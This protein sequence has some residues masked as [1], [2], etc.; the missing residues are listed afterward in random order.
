MKQP[1]TW[2]GGKQR[3]SKHIISLIPEHQIYTESFFGGGSIFFN[4]EPAKCEIINDLN[5]NLINFYQVLKTDFDELKKEVDKTLYSRDEFDYARFIYHYPNFFDNIKRAWALW[6][7]TYTTYCSKMDDTFITETSG[8]YTRRFKFSKENFISELS[9]R[10]NTVI[11]ENR[12]ALDI[13]T[14][15]DSETTFH[16]VDPPYINTICGTYNNIFNESNL[17]QLL[18]LLSTLQGKFIL[19]SYHNDLID[20]AIKK[21]GWNVKEVEHTVDSSGKNKK[22]VKELIIY[23]YL[24]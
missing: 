18:E 20:D 22:R 7:L 24:L 11:I 4:K 21:H 14:K 5:G 13:I 3:L 12:N 16:F 17:T 8:T 10:F 23:N 9:N 2:Y 15:F 19:T 6:Y 1:L